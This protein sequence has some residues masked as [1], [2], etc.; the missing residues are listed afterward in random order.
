MS[1]DYVRKSNLTYVLGIDGSNCY[2]TIAT[3]GD[4][5]ERY[6]DKV[7][8]GRKN[9]GGKLIGLPDEEL[10][11]NFFD[12]DDFLT[13]NEYGPWPF[14]SAG[15]LEKFFLNAVYLMEYSTKNL[16]LRLFN[17]EKHL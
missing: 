5:Y 7:A 10:I 16:E 15:C 3:W 4:G 12:D 2:I 1:M 11:Q 14:D 6:L 8:G 13:L 17:M 9:S